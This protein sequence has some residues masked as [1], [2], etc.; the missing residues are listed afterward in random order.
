MTVPNLRDG[1]APGGEP[2]M[3]MDTKM[4]NTEAHESVD[5]NE[6]NDNKERVTSHPPF[7]K[8]GSMGRE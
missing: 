6:S 8:L 3:V 5:M 4:L 1:V 2:K 7:G